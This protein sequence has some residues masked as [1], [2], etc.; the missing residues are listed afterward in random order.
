VQDISPLYSTSCYATTMG[1]ASGMLG[2]CYPKY[3]ISIICP[4]LP[5]LQKGLSKVEWTWWRHQHANS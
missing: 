3:I 2:P 1:V 5:I 4:I